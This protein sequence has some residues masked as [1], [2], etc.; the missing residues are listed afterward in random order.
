MGKKRS[1]YQLHL[2][3]SE[4]KMSVK[5]RG[6]S[7]RAVLTFVTFPMADEAPEK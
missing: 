1:Q 3:M 7:A 6:D 5:Y 2:E 4:S